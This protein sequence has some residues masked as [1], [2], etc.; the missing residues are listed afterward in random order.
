MFPNIEAERA[1]HGWSQEELANR[2]S[3]S[4]STIKNWMNG[5]TKI[6]ASKVV[7]M[8]ILFHCTT[9]YLLG[10]NERG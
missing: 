4:C 6:P 10:L 8:A 3:V 2:L 7:E 5:R 9:D 1:R